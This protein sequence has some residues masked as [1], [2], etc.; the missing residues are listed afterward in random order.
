MRPRH[1]VGSV[2][3]SRPISSRCASESASSRLLARRGE[4][5]ADDPM[6]VRV[7]YPLDQLGRHRPVH[8]P[9][10]AVVAQQEVVGDLTDGRAAAVRV[11]P[12]GEQELLLRR[13][14]SRRLSLLLAPAHKAPQPG[15]QGQQILVVGVSQ[16]HRPTILS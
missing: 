10:G 9:D 14:Q 13:R 3:P 4:L 15:P 6:V 11:P 16:N 2:R 8:Q 1:A 7:A 12:D 5:Q